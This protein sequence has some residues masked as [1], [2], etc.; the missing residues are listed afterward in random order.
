MGEVHEDTA[1]ARIAVARLLAR[2]V[3]PDPDASALFARA[4]C[5]HYASGLSALRL[6]RHFGLGNIRALTV[7]QELAVLMVRRLGELERAEPLLRRVVRCAV[8]PFHCTP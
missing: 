2:R 3:C 8:S 6:N 1:F 5:A 4:A 7:T